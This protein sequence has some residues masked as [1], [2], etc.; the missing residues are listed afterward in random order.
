[1]ILL[2]RTDRPEAYVG[3]WSKSTELA[4]SSW[5][6][7]RELSQQLHKVIEE[8]C[9]QARCKL[10]DI[11]AIVV[12]EGPGSYTG[13][14]IGV[15]V[16]NALAYS[17]EVPLVGAS[18]EKWQAEGIKLL[19]NVKYYIPIAPVYGGEVFTTKPKK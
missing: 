11:S 2:M 18:G 19:N 6:A 7:H 5:T 14:R 13:L 16:A 1:M 9:E 12:Y 4:A 17:L 8:V 10:D 3:L 15:S